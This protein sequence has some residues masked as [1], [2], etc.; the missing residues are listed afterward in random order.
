M[1]A[2]FMDENG[3]LHISYMKTWLLISKMKIAFS[4]SHI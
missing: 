1:G 3:T 4:I 2:Y